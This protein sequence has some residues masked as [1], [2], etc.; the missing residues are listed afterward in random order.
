MA[1]APNDKPI[2]PSAISDYNRQ[3]QLDEERIQGNSTIKPQRLETHDVPLFTHRSK[4]TPV[5][6]PSFI[7]KPQ[8]DR[9]PDVHPGQS[10]TQSPNDSG[11][12]SGGAA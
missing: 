11:R 12:R 7:Q 2:S 4:I 8:N 6:H 10:P 3:V 5:E 9:P 1:L